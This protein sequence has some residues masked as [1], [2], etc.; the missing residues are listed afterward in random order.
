MHPPRAQMVPRGSP[1]GPPGG[2]LALFGHGGIY[3]DIIFSTR[4]YIR[5]YLERHPGLRKV[6]ERLS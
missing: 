1:E 3:S 5:D 2:L 4:E 6:S